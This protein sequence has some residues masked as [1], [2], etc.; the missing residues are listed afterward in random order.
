MKKHLLFI[1]LIL[2]SITVEAQHFKLSEDAEISIITVGPG[3]NLVDSFGHSAI[4]VKDGVKGIDLA[5]N[6]GTYDFEAP[7]FYGNFAKGKLLYIVARNRFDNFL[8]YYRGQNRTVREQRLNLTS[9]EKQRYFNYLESN[10]RPENRG[11][12]YDFFYDN[13]ATKLR[14]VS[15]TVLEGQ[16]HFNYRFD[17]DKERSLRDLIHQ[18]SYTQPWGT[19]GIDLALGSVIDR[20]AKPEEYVFLPDYIFES[21]A[22]ARIKESEGEKPLI[23]QTNV[24]Y[25]ATKS[26][27][28]IGLSPWLVLLF[29]GLLIVLRTYFDFKNQKR[30]KWLDFTIFF[31]TGSIGLIMI[32]LWFATDHTATVKNLNVLWAVAPNL[33]MSFYVFKKSLDGWFRY[34]AVFL[35]LLLLILLVVAILK[36]Q[37]FNIAIYPLILA[38]AIRYLHLARSVKV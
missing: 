20:T 30:T 35:L 32:L 14:D 9:D 31:F 26:K 1:L 2:C 24:L 15:Q 38:F 8:N 17:P 22:Q 3:S 5:Y 29:V 18:Y 28:T 25:E 37:V 21:F 27:S 10:V 23:D 6:Y 19:L 34:Y 12:L 16:I 33:I 36:I 11:Y 4:R 7:N 13:C